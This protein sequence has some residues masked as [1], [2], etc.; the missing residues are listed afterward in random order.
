MLLYLQLYSNI[1]VLTQQIE[2]CAINFCMKILK[3]SYPVIEKELVIEF[4]KI[5]DRL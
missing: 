4:L 5:I 2:A 3:T 1:N